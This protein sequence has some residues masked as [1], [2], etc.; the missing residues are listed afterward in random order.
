[1]TNNLL[2]ALLVLATLVLALQLLALFRKANVDFSPLKKFFHSVQESQEQSEQAVRQEIAAN[3]LE[4]SSRLGQARDELNNSVKHFAN[5]LYQHLVPLLKNSEEKIDKMS[6][7][8]DLHLQLAREAIGKE[9]E[10]VRQGAL[11]ASKLLREDVNA[12]QRASGSVVSAVGEMGEVQKAQL[13]GFASGLGAMADSTKSALEA[14]RATIDERLTRIHEDG[15]SSSQQL[16]EELGN[17]TRD[18][19]QAQRTQAEALLANLDKLT[20]SS[21]RKLEAMK[22]AVE[23]KLQGIQEDNARQIDLMRAT[24]DERLHGLLEKRLDES[25]KL[26]GDRLVAVHAGLGEMRTL[27]DGIGDLKKVLSNVRSGGTLG[28]VLLGNLLQEILS[29]DQYAANVATKGPRERVEFA[30][31]LP[32]RVN[33]ADQ[34]VWLPISARFP[35]G[36]YER[37]LAAQDGA[38]GAGP[39]AAEI[40]GQ[41]FEKSVRD[42]AATIC[43]AYLDPPKT[44]EFAIMFLPSEGLYAEVARRVGL[45]EEIRR[46]FRVVITGPTTAA[47]LFNG[48]QMGFKTLASRKRSSIW[49]ALGDGGSPLAYFAGAAKSL[50]KK[51]DLANDGIEPSGTRI[52]GPHRKLTAPAALPRPNAAP[53]DPADGQ[54]KG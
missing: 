3:K 18:I 35:S 27:A 26:L 7:S 13:D 40:A 29:P 17:T 44:T 11:D 38:G 43:D 6:D 45:I 47:A 8:I 1:M 54:R 49:S 9:L 41:S 23:A 22:A 10:L 48:L 2:I 42:C 32:G 5:L 24:V 20:D 52:K 14:Q 51:L 33:R 36:E 37:L 28:E 19:A 25:F 12:A 50:K 46:E 15:A 34:A 31:K 53:A 21:E 39:D 4:L 16:R 30:I